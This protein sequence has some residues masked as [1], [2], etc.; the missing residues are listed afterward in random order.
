M[1]AAIQDVHPQAVPVRQS[2]K[3]QQV[4]EYFHR[5]REMVFSGPN[6]KL[7]DVW[8]EVWPRRALQLHVEV[9]PFRPK[10]CILVS[11]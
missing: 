11:L 2:L 5:D 9:L 3:V 7:L 8:H 10:L 4:H 6:Q 1:L